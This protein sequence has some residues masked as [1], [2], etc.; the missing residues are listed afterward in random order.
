MTT[1]ARSKRRAP[2]RRND[3]LPSIATHNVPS[4]VD[5]QVHDVAL[6]QVPRRIDVL[7]LAADEPRQVV[8][9]AAERGPDGAVPV[10]GHGQDALAVGAGKLA[11]LA[12]AKDGDAAS[13]IARPELART[14]DDQGVDVLGMGIVVVGQRDGL[15]RHAVEP[16]EAAGRAQPQK[17]V[18]RL[19]QGPDVVRRAVLRRPAGVLELEDRAGSGPGPG[20]D[21][22][23][24][25]SRR[26]ARRSPAVVFMMDRPRRPPV[27]ETLLSRSRVA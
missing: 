15:E 25:R 12:V 8:L 21:R 3:R 9:D 22:R 4:R 19:G 5:L 27:L 18:G 24:P 13:A 1:S 11:Q 16:I 14:G 23:E 20:P 10:L 6:R 17:A 7:P 2:R 26:I